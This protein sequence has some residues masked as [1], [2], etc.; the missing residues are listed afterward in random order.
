[1][2]PDRR[3]FLKQVTA[4][5][6][7]LGFVS[8]L[9]HSLFAQAGN[10]RVLP[11]TTPE[12]Q[13]VSSG[14]IRAFV[15]AVEKD[16]LGLHSLMV[17]RHGKV[18]A[19]GWWDP[20]QPELKHV[21]FSLSKS[22]TSTAVGFA[23]T[24]G[25]LKVADKVL[26][27]FPAEAPENPGQHLA[28]MRV[29]DLLTMTTGHDQDTM[30][31]LREEKQGGWA[32]KFLSLPVVHP[33]GTFF[34]YNTG[35]SYLLSAIVQRVTGQT[36]LDYLTPRLLQ[37]LGIEGADWETDPQGINTGGYGL[38]LTTED[39]AKFGQF[40]LRKGSWNGK[41]LLPEAWIGEATSFQ[42]PNASPTG[43]NPENDW[44]QGYGYQFWQCRHGAYRGDGAVGQFCIV[45]PAQ[46]AVVAITSETANMQQILN[47]VWNHLLP[48][49]TNAPLPADPRAP[50]LRQKLTSLTLL[51]AKS[52]AGSPLAA[53]VSG[54]SYQLADNALKGRTVS[55]DF[56]GRTG[57]F[58]LVDNR[59]EHRIAYG[60]DRW[61]KGETR[62]PVA[63]PP[64]DSGQEAT[65]A[66]VA[67]GGNWRDENTFV[68]TWVFFE[69]PHSDTVTCYFNGDTL[70]VEFKS[71]KLGKRPDYRET[72]P[73]L[74]GRWLA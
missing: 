48:A 68:M 72:R 33:P 24:E 60:L 39:I 28:A 21:L 43:K 11:R 16:N 18:V 34:L 19:E 73:V 57:A 13:G 47:Q 6:A 61:V 31:A 50:A 63:A 27:F 54:K 10:T 41:R 55:F 36:L 46:D 8:V 20:Y 9:P 45:L 40:Y 26:A 25:R 5:A 53:R 52:A 67:A 64:V 70:R 69:T 38:R 56:D 4:G 71:S 30:P 59:G 15:E 32:R 65:Q 2:S 66:K 49:M 35:A 74:E 1:M 22:F 3:N 62:M 44:H 29:K 12:L 51:P 7:G 58:T 17:V 37:P 14:G 23:V 42:V